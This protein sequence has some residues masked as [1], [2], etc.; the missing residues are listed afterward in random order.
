MGIKLDKD[1]DFVSNSGELKKINV[2]YHSVTDAFGLDG[3]VDYITLDVFEN[4]HNDLR[5]RGLVE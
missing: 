2:L 3:D 4:I 5:D 1:Y